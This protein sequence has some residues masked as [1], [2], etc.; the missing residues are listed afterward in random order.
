MTLCFC[1]KRPCFEGPRPPKIQVIWVPG[2][3]NLA[4]SIG[5]SNFHGE[6]S[7]EALDAYLDVHDGIS[8]GFPMLLKVVYDEATDLS[9]AWVQFFQGKVFN[10]K[11]RVFPTI[12]G[13]PNHPL[14]IGFSIINHP[15]WGNTPIFGNTQMGKIISEGW[16]CETSSIF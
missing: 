4:M 16:N 6:N 13:P 14:K 3:Y 11:I 9:S 8:K 7:C 5:R 15:L 2:T 12:G 10:L 1:S